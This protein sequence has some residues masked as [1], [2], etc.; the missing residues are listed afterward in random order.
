MM[1]GPVFPSLPQVAS[2]AAEPGQ[3]AAPVR[4]AEDP[5]AGTGVETRQAATP[6]PEGSRQRG[7]EGAIAATEARIQLTE[8]VARRDRDRLERYPAE[9]DALR[10]AIDA[11]ADDLARSGLTERLGQFET[12]LSAAEARMSVYQQ[13][14]P[15][16]RTALETQIAGYKTQLAKAAYGQL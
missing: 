10:S 1:I 7:L 2:S 4:P 9:M 13:D 8:E 5:R 11:S 3:V 14:W 15:E 12:A 16:Q 6:I